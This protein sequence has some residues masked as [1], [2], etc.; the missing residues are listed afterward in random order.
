M[1]TSKLVAQRANAIQASGIR[2]IFDM[3]ATLRDPIDLSIGQPHFDVQDEVKETAIKAI[4]EGFNRYTP[5]GGISDIKEAVLDRFERMHGM[6]PEG[7][8]MTSGVSG[9]L[10]VS[11]LA[12]VD[13]GDEVLVLDPYF[14]SYKQL[15]LM[16]GGTPVFF[17]TYP[18]FKIDM[19]KL[20][21]AVT[22]KSK[23]LLAMSPGNPTGTCIDDATKKELAAFAR[24]NGLIVVSDEIYES[25]TYE[26]GTGKSLAC[27]YPE[28][29]LALGGLS[30]ISSMTGWRVGWALGPESLLNAMAKIQQFTFVCA[31]SF[32][33]KAA[34][35]AMDVDLTETVK[36]YQNKRDFM[37]DG[38][39]SAGYEVVNPGG[40]FYLFV[41]APPSYAG[42]Q[43]FV[44]AAVNRG[45]LM[46]PG[47]AFSEKDTHFR[48][49]FAASDERLKQGLNILT[50]LY[51]GT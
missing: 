26:G 41:K 37:V 36:S 43:A 15:T 4:K 46:V 49:S 44:E 35:T 31:P 39:R 14:V 2:K 7:A 40:A 20:E 42:G 24:K 21:D 51:A 34:L 13:P 25:F 33:Q 11:L 17:D 18:E 48:I 16:C 5:T 10:S 32:A 6:R 29:T 27:Y 19:A 28:G 9:A 22:P 30:K 1:D 8:M 3:A 50:Q 47:N 12:L 23:V 38:L 45:L